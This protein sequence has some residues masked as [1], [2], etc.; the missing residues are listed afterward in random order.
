MAIEYLYPEVNCTWSDM[1]DD[2]RVGSHHDTRDILISSWKTS[3][4][5]TFGAVNRR[6]NRKATDCKVMA[7]PYLYCGRGLED[8]WNHVLLLRGSGLDFMR[9]AW[10]KAI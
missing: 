6:A 3:T 9:D 1:T 8:K 4:R 5:N 10:R 7:G 2:S